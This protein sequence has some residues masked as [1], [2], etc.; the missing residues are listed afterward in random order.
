MLHFFLFLYFGLCSTAQAQEIRI[1]YT[2]ASM[3][4]GS[5]QYDFVLPDQLSKALPEDAPK[6]E[7]VTPFHG[8]LAQGQFWVASVDGKVSSIVQFLKGPIT[9]QDPETAYLLQTDQE[10]F[11]L[12]GPA[13]PK[14]AATL[15]L[16]GS[17]ASEATVRS[18][19]SQGQRVIVMTEGHLVKELPSWDLADFEFRLGLR[20]GLAE[21]AVKHHGYIIGVPLNEGARRFALLQSLLKDSPGALYVDAG[22]FVD[23]NSSVRNDALSL[24][25]PIGFDMLRRLAPAA[26]VPG[27]TELAGGPTQFLAEA[28]E[29]GLP[30]V[31]VNWKTDR[32]DLVLPKVLEHTV[33]SEGGLLTIAFIGVVDPDLQTQI[34]HLKAEGVALIEPVKAVQ[35][36]VDLLKARPA[37]PNAIVLLS[38][39]NP[40]LMQEI[41]R[42]VQG[43]DLVL[44]DTAQPIQR[45]SEATWTLVD[46]KG[47]SSL[48]AAVPPM[49]DIMTAD[50]HFDGEARPAIPGQNSG[51]PSRHPRDHPTGS[52]RT[53]TGNRNPRHR[54]PYPRRA[55]CPCRPPSTHHP[56]QRSEMGTGRL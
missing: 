53:Q 29:D 44:G 36:Q 32:E 14:W 23:G 50:L 37:P 54:I 8:L 56:H 30:Y 21:G 19:E 33:E 13:T 38:A 3:G 34:H 1:V 55:A 47:R 11:V 40:D 18:C 25:R 26:L 5:G 17:T 45:L 39:G 46:P 43:L 48:P 35:E 16:K 31:A 24:H 12:P 28:R 41:R 49:R 42:D 6:P 27:Q 52:V 51:A 10:R 7:S 20:L 4:I 22:S 2:G 15:T 9:C